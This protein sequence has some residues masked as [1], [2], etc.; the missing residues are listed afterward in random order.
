[1]MKNTK[2]FIRKRLFSDIKHLKSVLLEYIDDFVEQI[3]F[4]TLKTNFILLIPNIYYK[5]IQN[6]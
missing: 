2:H 1:M 4:K 6:Y 5:I 3:Q